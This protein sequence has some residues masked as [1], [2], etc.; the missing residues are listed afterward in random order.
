LLKNE[1]FGAIVNEKNI[2]ENNFPIVALG[3]SAGQLQQG[4][5]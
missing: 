2:K 3:A 4:T 1:F 5:A